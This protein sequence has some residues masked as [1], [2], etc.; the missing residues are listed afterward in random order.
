MKILWWSV[1]ILDWYEFWLILYFQNIFVLFLILTLFLW[2]YIVL[3]KRNIL[4]HVSTSIEKNNYSHPRKSLLP[5]SNIHHPFANPLISS[6]MF[7]VSFQ[8]FNFYFS[9]LEVIFIF[10]EKLRD[11][12]SFDFQEHHN[13]IPFRKLCP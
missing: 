3:L 9:V 2:C 8:P 5:K 6:N 4:I 10:R 11:K 13:L 12:Y 1:V 7:F